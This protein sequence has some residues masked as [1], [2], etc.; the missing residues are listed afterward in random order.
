MASGEVTDR[1]RSLWDQYAPRYDRDT[2]FYD[3]FLRHE[4]YDLSCSVV[5]AY[6]HVH[7]GPATSIGSARSSKPTGNQPTPPSSGQGAT[8]S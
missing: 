1:L 7:R 6:G 5:G 3:L 8:S 4:L 2:S